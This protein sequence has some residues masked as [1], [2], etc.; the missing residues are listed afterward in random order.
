MIRDI[1]PDPYQRYDSM[2]FVTLEK[3]MIESCSVPMAREEFGWRLMK[4]R[5]FLDGHV[6]VFGFFSDLGRYRFPAVEFRGDQM[7]LE[8]DTLLAVRDSFASYT[9]LDIDSMIPWDQPSRLRNENMNL[10]LNLL[11]SPANKSTMTYTGVVKTSNGS[12]DTTICVD[13]H[14]IIND[15]VYS[16]PYAS[17]FHLEDSIAVLYYNT[18]MIYGEDNVKQYRG[19][20]DTFFSELKSKHIKYLFID[21]THN[22]GGSDGH[23]SVIINHLRTDESITKVRMT[24]KKAGVEKYLKSDLVKKF[25]GENEAE[26]NYWME[27]FGNPIMEKGIAFMEE[28]TPANKSGYDGNVFVIMGNKTYSAGANFCLAIKRSNAAILVGEKAGQYYPICGNAIR[29]TLPNSKIQ[30]QIPATETFYEPSALF[31]EGYIQPDIYYSIEEFLNVNNYKEIVKR[32][33]KTACYV[34]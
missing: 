34:R 7:L 23:N 3:K 4:V 29:N 2:T 12:R 25:F 8:S 19:F 26:K 15:S 13:T 31:E 20:V 14:R 21:V 1:H 22:G 27:R 10:L 24:G 28:S 9:A 16:K 30:Y 32:C 5:K 11:L 18:C 17:A 33:C 6:A